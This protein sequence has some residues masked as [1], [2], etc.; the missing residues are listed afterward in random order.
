MTAPAPDESAARRIAYI[1]KL[2]DALLDCNRLYWIGA[3]D[4]ERKEARLMLA[5]AGIKAPTEKTMARREAERRALEESR[6]RDAE[7]K[8]RV[9]EGKEQPRRAKKKPAPSK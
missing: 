5:R 6:R 1:R 8:T 2:A 7:E 9:A 4:E 3:T